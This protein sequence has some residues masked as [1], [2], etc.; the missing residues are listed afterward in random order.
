MRALTPDE[1][2]ARLLEAALLRPYLCGIDP[3]RPDDAAGRLRACSEALPA[4][5]SSAE[6]IIAALNRFPTAA[7]GL[8]RGREQPGKALAVSL[9]EVW[10]P[11]ARPPDSVTH[12]FERAAAN[13]EA[14]ATQREES[15]RRLREKNPWR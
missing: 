3:W 12:L 1:K 6:R 14:A 4:V 5:S 15:V 13:I 2:K 11:T 9:A 8:I 7:D 10:W